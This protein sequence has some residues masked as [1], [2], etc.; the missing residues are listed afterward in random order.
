MNLFRTKSKYAMGVCWFLDVALVKTQCLLGI[1]WNPGNGS[2]FDS[3]EM[4]AAPTPE[5]S[6][7]RVPDTTK[8]V[9]L[10]SK[11]QSI[12]L[13]L[14]FLEIELGW[15]IEKVE[16]PWTFKNKVQRGHTGGKVMRQV[17]TGIEGD[18]ASK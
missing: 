16:K 12:T 18:D 10:F 11:S 13:H 15:P 9:K 17:L 8:P 5:C 2:W 7:A 6:W 4:K 14:F 3:W 1:S